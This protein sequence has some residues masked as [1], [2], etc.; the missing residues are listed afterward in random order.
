MKNINGEVIQTFG[1]DELGT[2]SVGDF[3][4]LH[5]ELDLAR[6]ALRHVIDKYKVVK[7]RKSSSPDTEMVY[8][9]YRD[10]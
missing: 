5:S 10:M 6:Q 3:F 7:S 2:I 9:L 1:K 8:I 4:I